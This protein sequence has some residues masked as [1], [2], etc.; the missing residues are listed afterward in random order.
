MGR[1][2][3][4]L[5][6]EERIE[7]ARLSGEGASIRKIAAALGRA[8]SSIARELKRNTGSQVGYQPLYADA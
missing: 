5:G 6:L 3:S 8:P 1:E 7:I 4:Q 2:Y